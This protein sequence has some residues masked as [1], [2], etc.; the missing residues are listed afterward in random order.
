MWRKA[1]LK[2]SLRRNI[3]EDA[4]F[5]VSHRRAPFRRPCGSWV[6][7]MIVLPDSRLSRSMSVEHVLGGLPVEV[8]CRL[9]GHEY[10][11]VGDDGPGNGHPLLL[12]AGELA[13]GNGPCGRRG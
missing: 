13:R 4:L 12:A 10:G 7:M 8:A 9:V 5:E 1:F 2:S 6:T 3:V 11:G